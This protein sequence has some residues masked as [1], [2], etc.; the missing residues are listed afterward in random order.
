MDTQNINTYLTLGF[1]QDK[2][3]VGTPLYPK[4]VGDRNK[5]S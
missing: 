2:Q 1:Q 3:K 4:R 5:K